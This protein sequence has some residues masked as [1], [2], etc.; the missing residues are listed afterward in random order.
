MWKILKMLEIFKKCV[1][2][3]WKYFS[4]FDWLY[5][6]NQLKSHLFNLL[7]GQAKFQ[8]PK[9]YANKQLSNPNWRR[10]RITRLELF[11][12]LRGSYRH[13]WWHRRL[14]SKSSLDMLF[15][16]ELM[17]LRGLNQLGTEAA[18]VSLFA[19]EKPDLAIHSI[20]SKPQVGLC[21]NTWV[22]TKYLMQVYKTRLHEAYLDPSTRKAM[23]AMG[24]QS[25]VSY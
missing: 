16:S 11:L 13:H 10:S 12:G 5:L 22:S 19:T 14:D 18:V 4:S 24:P 20:Y 23:L 2:Y 6:F 15:L 1:R 25:F 3:W 21:S 17:L 7:W 8:V 9:F